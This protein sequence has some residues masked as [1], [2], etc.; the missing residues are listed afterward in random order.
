M[1]RKSSAQNNFFFEQKKKISKETYFI[2]TYRARSAYLD[3]EKYVSIFNM[4]TFQ[5]ILQVFSFN[6]SKSKVKR[7]NLDRSKRVNY[8]KRK[9]SKL[10]DYPF[11]SA[12]K[13]IDYLA[14]TACIFACIFI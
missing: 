4:S 5:N 7:K 14:N 12:K 13:T 9:I 10:E 3:Y 2:F 11:S 8:Y 6:Y 1:C